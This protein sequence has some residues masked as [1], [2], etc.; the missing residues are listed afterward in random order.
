MK[1]TKLRPVVL[2]ILD[3]WGHREAADNNAIKLGRTP[4]FD[5]LWQQAPHALLR[6]SA[7]DVGLPDGQMGNS[8][9]GH[10]NLGAGR[11][12]QQ[13]L[14]R[15]DRA[16]ADGTLAGNPVLGELVTSLAY[17]G[18]ACHLIGLL[19]PGG[20]HA[21]SAHMVALARAV[22]AAGLEV[23]VHGL[24]DGRDTPPKSAVGFVGEF[25]LAV[26]DEPR[27]RIASLSG[28]Y[29]A[30]D[31]DKRWERT[32]EAYRMLVAGDGAR[33]NTVTEAIETAYD[34]DVSDEFVLPVA[35]QGY[36]GM[37]DGDGLLCAN[38]RADRM[39]QILSA[40]VDPVFDG[41]DRGRC[42]QFAA[43]AGLVSYSQALD[44]Y[45][46]P[47]FPTAPLDGTLPEVVA[48]AGLTQ[49]RIAE[50]EK[51]AH[52]TFFLNGGSELT[53]KG[54]ERILIPSPR[55][56]T[57]DLK[58]EM[59]APEV[60]DQLVDAIR[61]G[62]FDFIVVNYANADMV[63]HSGD[64]TAT[65]KAVEAVDRC[66]GRLETA[67]ADAGGALLITADHGNAETMLDPD[68]ASV[69]T[70][71]TSNP[72]PVLLVNAGVA[73][74]ALRDGRLADVA[75]TLL[76]LLGL[77]IP[78]AMTGR[79]LLTTRGSASTRRHESRASA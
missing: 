68:T 44:A 51:Y 9:V 45:L 31:R 55:V 58:P 4:I 69:H 25:E 26:A 13:D 41:F 30:M 8:E 21:H 66:L 6:T 19:S 37:A 35:I 43:M 67:V 46:P 17:S 20:V 22:A 54:E 79:S 61:G 10:Q 29:Y 59:S 64:L 57:Y 23:R 56:A 70:A 60:T 77:P 1:H 12:V 16:V 32:A 42:V 18:G 76:E 2:C 47:L 49:L 39:R 73:G 52:V 14:P 34:K 33:A 48:E 71:H 74:A 40:T 28:R 75:P 53:F 27:I 5:R 3:G 24:L 36:A 50:T 62:H 63:G 65:I 7:G 11:V 38:F 72:V 78:E 15:I